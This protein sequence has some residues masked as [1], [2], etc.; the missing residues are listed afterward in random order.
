MDF[1]EGDPWILRRISTT[2]DI[3]SRGQD[4]FKLELNGENVHTGPTAETPADR[5]R[6]HRIL[7]AIDDR[8]PAPYSL[9]GD[10]WIDDLDNPYS[11]RE[12]LDMFPSASVDLPVADLV[13]ALG[14]VWN[15]LKIDAFLIE[16]NRLMSSSNSGRAAADRLARTGRRP[17]EPRL[18]IEQYSSDLVQR[19]K[20]VRSDYAK[21]TSELDSTFPER[22]VQFLRAKTTALAES[23]V[24]AKLEELDRKRQNL[25]TLGFLEKESGLGSFKDEDA[26]LAREALTI[27]VGDAE[28]KLNVFD[29]MAA[30]AGKLMEILSRRYKYKTFRISQ[31]AGFV[32][33][34]STGINI[35]LKD[36][37][38]GE[39]H[40]LILLYELLFRTPSN[41]LIL[42][43]EPE[44]S[45]HVGWQTRF[46]SDLIDIVKLNGAYS[47]V[48]THSPVLIGSKWNLTTSLRGP[49]GTEDSREDA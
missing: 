9:M 20:N 30:R 26:R 18:R 31:E 5:A 13:F 41:G 36:L 10:H 35:N 37:S 44:I 48:A 15:Q 11:P 19:I 46:L 25:T 43:D 16:A 8:V 40:E 24:V 29:D 2:P 7:D 23:A 38:S 12:I 3:R 21:V 47:L 27:Y 1:D 49:L 42:V 34:S 4:D 14:G 17:P 22:L 32:V 6:L 45:L 33:E 28:K 39:Q